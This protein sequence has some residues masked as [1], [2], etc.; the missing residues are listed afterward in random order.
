MEF[1][2]DFE[3]ELIEYESRFFRFCVFFRCFNE[4]LRGVGR[5]FIF[6]LFIVEDFVIRKVV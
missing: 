3:F 2:F 4:F 1:D 5:G 6:G